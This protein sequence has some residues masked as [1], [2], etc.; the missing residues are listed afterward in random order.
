MLGKPS[1][2]LIGRDDVLCVVATR[3]LKHHG[4]TSINEAHQRHVDTLKRINRLEEQA[5]PAQP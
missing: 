1:K 4:K 5:G 3:T 2:A